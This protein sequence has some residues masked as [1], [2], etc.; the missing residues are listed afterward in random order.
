M[1][2]RVDSFVITRSAARASLVAVREGTVPSVQRRLYF[3][4]FGDD[5]LLE[6]RRHFPALWHATSLLNGHADTLLLLYRY[7][8]RPLARS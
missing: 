6:N 5:V 4:D 3:F 2:T 7:V 8:I 1:H